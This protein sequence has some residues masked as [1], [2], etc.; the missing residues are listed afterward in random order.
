M[1]LPTIDA[2][3]HFLSTTCHPRVE[4]MSP[5]E[6]PALLAVHSPHLAIQNL[7]STLIVVPIHYISSPQPAQSKE[8]DL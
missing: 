3:L 1:F 7:G 8:C 5:K 2:T 6:V 4:A